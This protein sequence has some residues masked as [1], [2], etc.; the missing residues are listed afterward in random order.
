MAIFYTNEVG[1]TIQLDADTDTRI[2]LT[3]EQIKMGVKLIHQHTF[4]SGDNGVYEINL[5]AVDYP[6]SFSLIS[7]A[8]TRKIEFSR[9]GTKYV[10]AEYDIFQPDVIGTT[11]TS[12]MVK[13]RFTAQTGDV[14]SWVE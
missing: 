1:I 4:I 5:G 9:E 7:S 3:L 13:V 10:Q 8:A 2:G 11:L 6:A 14:V 12:K